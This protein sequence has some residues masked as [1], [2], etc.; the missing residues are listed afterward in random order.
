LA[1]GT[2]AIRT[3]R[4]LTICAVDRFISVLMA[5]PTTGLHPHR[6]AI[7]ANNY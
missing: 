3:Y 6:D 2:N 4:L 7:L 1:S 5:A